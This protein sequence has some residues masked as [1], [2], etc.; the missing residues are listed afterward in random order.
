[1][2]LVIECRNRRCAL[3]QTAPQRL[4]HHCLEGL[5]RFPRDLGQPV[6]KIVFDREG[7][8]HIDIMMPLVPDVKMPLPKCTPEA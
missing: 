7:C 1:M 5:L 8:P 2:R 6:G 4:V 3:G